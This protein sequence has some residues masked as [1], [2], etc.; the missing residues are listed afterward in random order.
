MELTLPKLQLIMPLAKRNAALYLYPLNRAMVLCNI[1]TP[2]R[3][4]MWLA[5]VAHESG[6]LNTV[7]E[8]LNYKAKSLVA[9]WPRRFTINEALQYEHK[10]ALIANRVYGGRYGNNDEKS[11]DGW[12]FRGRG[13]IQITFKS[14]Y[15]TCGKF[16]GQD[17]VANPDLLLKPEYG[18]LSAGWFWMTAD[19]NDEADKQD[20][21]GCTKI[22]NGP[23]LNG[24]AARQAFYD[25]AKSVLV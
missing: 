11:G 2:L 6:Q 4:A 20:I 8:N 14:N 17:L 7:E 23:A 19:L 5:Q 16:I 13:P 1:N 24:L 3:A 9:I 25:I 21:V 22:I 10:P 18:A 15:D 12:K